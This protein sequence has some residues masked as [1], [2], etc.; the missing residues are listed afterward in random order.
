MVAPHSATGLYLTREDE[1]DR[2]VE[3][4]AHIIIYTRYNHDVEGQIGSIRGNQERDGPP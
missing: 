4:L 2:A 1:F 3:E